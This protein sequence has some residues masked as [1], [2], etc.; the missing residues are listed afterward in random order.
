MNVLVYNYKAVI[1]G[2]HSAD[3]IDLEVG[4]GFRMQKL[5]RMPVVG[6]NDIVSD[7]DG[8]TARNLLRELLVGKKVYI[9]TTRPNKYGKTQCSVYIAVKKN[10]I[11][12]EHLTCTYAGVI[13]IPYTRLLAYASDVKYD[14]EKVNEVLTVL[15]S[16]DV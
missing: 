12:F 13:L 2:F 16:Y 8:I 7:K 15:E 3:V 5:L 10:N 11:M 1:S 6:V 14:K 4:L 9:A